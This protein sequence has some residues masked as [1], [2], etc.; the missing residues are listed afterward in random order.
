MYTMQVMLA[1]AAF[2][3]FFMLITSIV[4]TTVGIGCCAQV[5]VNQ[6]CFYLA[7]R[8]AK[9]LHFYKNDPGRGARS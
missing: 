9:S 7:T 4:L 3:A 8:W 5:F 2:I 1:I 6:V